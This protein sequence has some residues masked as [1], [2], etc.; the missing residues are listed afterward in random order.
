MVCKQSQT[1]CNPTHSLSYFLVITRQQMQQITPTVNVNHFNKQQHKYLRPLCT[2]ACTTVKMP[3]ESIHSFIHSLSHEISFW[4]TGKE[5]NYCISWCFT[6]VYFPPLRGRKWPYEIAT[7]SVCFCVRLSICVCH[8]AS[9][10][11]IKFLAEFSAPA[12]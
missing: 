2:K 1:V 8:K 4:K 3:K 12:A 10:T 11:F 9:F 7:L 6:L 5:T